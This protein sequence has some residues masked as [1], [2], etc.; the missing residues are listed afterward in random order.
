MSSSTQSSNGSLLL[1]RQLLELTKKPVEGFSAGPSAPL[2]LYLHHTF[3]NEVVLYSSSCPFPSRK[4][5][6][7]VRNRPRRRGQH[8]RMGDHHHRV[9]I[10]SYAPLEQLS[11]LLLA[12]RAILS[13][14][15]AAPH[16]PRSTWAGATSAHRPVRPAVRCSVIARVRVVGN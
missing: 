8:L 6:P 12:A 2:L 15:S 10:R 5:T 7:G 3:T 14:E 9:R 16:S 4:L 11:N 13:S 1:R